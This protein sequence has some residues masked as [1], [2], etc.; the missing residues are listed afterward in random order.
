MGGTASQDTP[1]LGG[2]FA[3]VGIGQ[4][5]C[6]DKAVLAPPAFDMADMS[7]ANVTKLVT[8]Q[9]QQLLSRDADPMELSAALALAKSNANATT[10]S[11]QLCQTILRA[12]P[13]IF[14]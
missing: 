13:F 10:T 6:D 8:F 5:Y 9:F 12:S 4:H 14:Y 1:G 2:L 11:K 3:Q 7:D